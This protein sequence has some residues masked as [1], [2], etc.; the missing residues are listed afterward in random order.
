M[1]LLIWVIQ[2]YIQLSMVTTDFFLKHIIMNLAS[3]ILYI[4][5]VFY[6][7]QQW[8]C[9][10]LHFCGHYT[11][12]KTVNFYWFKDSELLLIAF[13]ACCGHD[14]THENGDRWNWASDNSTNRQ[15][16]HPRSKCRSFDSTSLPAHIWGPYRW[17]F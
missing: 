1:S 14:E 10:Y 4:Y 6:S 7:L 2:N 8:L 5:D 3:T 12:L 11:C 13:S 16:A 17:D 9:L 15:S